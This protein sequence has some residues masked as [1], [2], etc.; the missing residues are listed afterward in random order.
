MAHLTLDTVHRHVGDPVLFVIPIDGLEQL[1]VGIAAWRCIG[2]ADVEKTLGAGVTVVTGAAARVTYPELDL[3]GVSDTEA[4]LVVDVDPA[5]TTA[6]G[7]G[8]CRWQ[9]IAGGAEAPVVAEGFLVLS[10]TLPPASM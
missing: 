2:A 6:L 9:A 10:R 7:V 5:D 1:D 8:R 3:S 4:V